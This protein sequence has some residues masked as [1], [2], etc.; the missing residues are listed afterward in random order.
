MNVVGFEAAGWLGW[1][2]KF[3]SVDLMNW[4]MKAY[5]RVVD[6]DIVNR[7]GQLP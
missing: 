3:K 2:K 6:S 1:W 4:F 5:R 7:L